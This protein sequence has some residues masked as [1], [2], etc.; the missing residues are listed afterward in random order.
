MKRILRRRANEPAPAPE[1]RR[2]PLA[3][4]LTFLLDERDIDADLRA[5]TRPSPPPTRHHTPAHNSTQ[6]R[7]H[8]N[9]SSCEFRFI[10]I[11]HPWS[12]FR[13]LN[14]NIASERSQH[15]RCPDLLGTSR[16]SGVW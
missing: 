12:C 11:S 3:T 10:I 2:K 8:L 15:A 13:K 14:C 5:I 1:K 7:K 9:S 4:T 6:P 16:F